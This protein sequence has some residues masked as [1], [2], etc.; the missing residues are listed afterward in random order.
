M[1]IVST[2]SGNFKKKELY[3]L[4]LSL[5]TVFIFKHIE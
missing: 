5:S 4:N 3:I 1:Y 2:S